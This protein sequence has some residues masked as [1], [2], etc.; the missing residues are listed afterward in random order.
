M[1]A[2]E[3]KAKITNGLIRVPDKFRQKTGDTVKVIILRERKTNQ[4]DI[5]DKLLSTPLKSKQFS[6]L[7]REEIYGRF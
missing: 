3:F 6:P 4:P 1:E 2:I 5:I 7:P